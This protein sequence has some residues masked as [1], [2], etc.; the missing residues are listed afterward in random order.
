M[1]K[2]IFITHSSHD[3]KTATKIRDYLEANGV[4]CWMAPRDIPVGAEWAEAILNGI[5]NAS[6]ML[7]VF[8]SNSNDSPQVRREIERAIHNDLPVFPIRI[9]N[10]VPSKAME[11]Y[12]SSNHWMD[13]F[14]SQLE[15]N[16]LKLVETIKSKVFSIEKTDNYA[17]QETNVSTK[18]EEEAQTSNPSTSAK[19]GIF[20]PEFSLKHFFKIPR[21]VFVP[22]LILLAVFIAF[23]VF[24]TIFNNQPV[25]TQI[26]IGIQDE[27]FAKVISE[28]GMEL[29]CTSIEQA[30]DGGYL[31]TGR[32]SPINTTETWR[33]IW[34]KKLGS[35]GNEEWE[36]TD[37]DTLSTWASNIQYG[38]NRRINAYELTDTTI[39]IAYSIAQIDTIIPD[40]NQVNGLRSRIN[41]PS[42]TSINEGVGFEIIHLDRSGNLI[43]SNEI[44]WIK[45]AWG[46]CE[47]TLLLSNEVGGA[48]VFLM[49]S[50]I[51][52]P[53]QASIMLCFDDID[54]IQIEH[55]QQMYLGKEP[56]NTAQID[57]N[58][59]T[60]CIND[61]F[62]GMIYVNKIYIDFELP[63]ILS[64]SVNMFVVR[65]GTAKGNFN[66]IESMLIAENSTFCLSYV[67]DSSWLVD[68]IKVL[69][70]DEEGSRV[71]ESE[72]M[73]IYRTFVRKLIQISTNELVFAAGTEDSSGVIRPYIGIIENSG[74][75]LWEQIIPTEGKAEDVDELNSG[76]LIFAINQPTNFLLLE[77]DLVG[78]YNSSLFESQHYHF[79][80]DWSDSLVDPIIWSLSHFAVIAETPDRGQVLKVRGLS[81]RIPDIRLNL[82]ILLKPGS[83]IF[84]DLFIANPLRDPNYLQLGLFAFNEDTSNAEENVAFA[85]FKWN[86][87]LDERSVVI[88]SFGNESMAFPDSQY[89]RYGEWNR[90]C[91]SIDS[92]SVN[93]FINDIHVCGN[94]LT[95]GVFGRKAYFEIYGGSIIPVYVDSIAI[96]NLTE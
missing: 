50:N 63:N 10:V 24:P 89:V 71:Y 8:S 40:N 46:M 37:R 49:C 15:V 7:L 44:R 31:V 32:R 5:E 61:I 47:V 51:H 90:F 27:T 36:F 62:A 12:I 75:Y 55:L 9:E 56:V 59:I 74:G 69:L 66:C 16:L 67:F 76:N 70:L 57:N 41:N 45:G 94:I 86:Y 11:Y 48:C 78:N 91:I 6:G 19:E 93:Y 1:N 38:E 58:Q 68:S 30:F 28:D 34:I 83:E 39:V 80:E 84:A 87:S 4:Q 73:G 42:D 25:E 96:R 65:N 20:K 53:G 81:N 64:R 29:S 33:E 14:D 2:Y 17:K 88:S 85:T 95:D 21:N 82:G 3:V 54:N 60:Y 77:V 79:T 52:Y 13:A 35:D 43:S 18:E 26:N 92:T 72:R 22:I 23:L